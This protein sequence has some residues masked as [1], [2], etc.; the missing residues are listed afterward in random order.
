[1][2]EQ[3]RLARQFESHRNHLIA[4]AYRIL[5]SLGEA[6]DAVQESWLR[7]SRAETDGIHNLGGWLTTV[8]SRICLDMLRSRRSRREEPMEAFDSDNLRLEERS[9]IDPEQEAL[10]ADSVGL[11]L[12]VVLGNLRPAERIAFVMHDIFGMPFS[13]VAAIVGRSEQAARQLGSRARR[14]V[15]GAGTTPDTDL[16][17][18]RS[19]VDA[20]LAAARKGDFDSLV[21]ALAPEVVLRDD[22]Q[23]GIPGVTLSAAAL[24]KHLAGRAQAAQSAL[25]NGSVG[26]VAAP[27]GKLLYVLRFTMRSGMIAEVDLIADPARIR[28][29]E[30]AVCDPPARS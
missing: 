20:F 25:V 27:G 22:R 28:E 11:A 15:H 30:L 10:L 19:V 12:L 16:A 18:Q 1:M 7:L 14:R 17:E 3:E 2:S 26:A 21:A 13:E 5:G 24:A 4:V 29:L 6:E 23:A 9:P 8:V